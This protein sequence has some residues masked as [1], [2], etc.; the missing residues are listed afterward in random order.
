MV[1][2]DF[3]VAKA[4][5]KLIQIVDGRISGFSQTHSL[6]TIRDMDKIYLDSY[7]N[8]QLPR[9]LLDTLEVQKEVSIEERENGIFLSQEEEK[10]KKSKDKK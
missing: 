9:Y 4:T 6:K 7:G 5:D 1:T 8:L 10:P 3:D 2:H